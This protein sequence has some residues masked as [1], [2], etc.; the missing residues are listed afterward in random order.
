MAGGGGGEAVEE[1]VAEALVGV[2]LGDGVGVVDGGVWDV[3]WCRAGVGV[4][5]VEADGE[6][7]L[8]SGDEVVAGEGGLGTRGGVAMQGERGEA[9]EEDGGGF[10]DRVC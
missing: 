5:T 2:E 3:W 8:F 9:E 4:G 10:A 1:G 6:G 7:G